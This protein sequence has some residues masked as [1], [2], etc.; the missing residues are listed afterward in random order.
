ME[1]SF[2]LHLQRFFRTNEV[3]LQYL[4]VRDV[5]K[6]HRTH[7]L[8]GR[9]TAT[10]ITMNHNEYY[11]F[12]IST[13]VISDPISYV[14]IIPHD[15]CEARPMAYDGVFRSSLPHPESSAKHMMTTS[16]RLDL[17]VKCHEDAQVVF[18]QGKLSKGAGLLNIV[19]TGSGESEAGN[20]GSN[21]TNNNMDQVVL[22]SPFWDA[23]QQTSWTPRRPY[24]LPDLANV[25]TNFWKIN[26]WNVTMDFVMVPSEGNV[27]KPQTKKE[28]SINHIRWDPEIAI[29]EL[30]LGQLVEWTLINTNA[31]PFHIHIN[32]MQIVQKGGCGYRYEEGEYYDT[33]ASDDP[34][35]VRLQFWDFSGR[36]VA[37]CHKLSHED[38]GMMVWIDVMGSD[39]G[40]NGTAQAACSD[41]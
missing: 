15:A 41:F 29:R 33:I 14:E 18:H 27:T 12:R 24:Y 39:H 26:S 17:A 16:S 21:N 4:C 28:W 13:V 7:L 19:V 2:P 20:G 11:N 22:A 30:Q 5:D 1:T 31:H 36:V 9:A 35:L 6:V 38:D 23:E 37:H 3:L 32:K 8:N 10:N 25:N 40:V 34:C